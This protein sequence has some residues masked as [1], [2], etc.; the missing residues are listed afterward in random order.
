[1]DLKDIQ[2]S[3]PADAALV[4]W[5]DL[6]PAGPDAADPDGEHWGVVVRSEGT[7][8]WIPLPGTDPKGLWSRDDTELTKRLRNELRSRPGPG[9]VGTLSL[10]KRLR[11]QRIEP[12]AEALAATRGLPPARRLI[13]LP[14]QAL[15]GVPIEALLDPDDRRTVSYAPSATVLK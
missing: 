7:P 8:A 9:S 15:A 11:T 13:V 3:L 4:A 5:V 2:A 6:P 14:S 12:L 1:A 10:L